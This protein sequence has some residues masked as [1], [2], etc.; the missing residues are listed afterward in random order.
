MEQYNRFVSSLKSSVLAEYAMSKYSIGS[1]NFSC[2]EKADVEKMIL[3]LKPKT[4][5]DITLISHVTRKY[6]KFLGEDRVQNILDDICREELWK[7]AKPNA[8]RRFISFS[9]YQ[10][11]CDKIDIYEDYNAFYKNVLFRCIYE[12]IYSKKL[13]VI[14]NLRASDIHGN[15]VTLRDDDGDTFVLAISKELAEDLKELGKVN[16][17]DRTNGLGEF[18]VWIDG[19]HY[20]SCFKV[21]YRGGDNDT[22]Y[23]TSYLR[24]LREICKLYL[25]RKVSPMKIYVSGIMHRIGVELTK[26]GLSIEEA[27]TKCKGDKRVLAII[28]E[29]LKRSGYSNPE[30]C[31]REYVRGHLDEFD[32]FC[33]IS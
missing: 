28:R 1:L 24:A 31:L 4:P 27:F 23:R 5:R 33:D 3:D 25:N 18:S 11:V 17:W 29:E 12:G 19:M 30:N 14:K 15:T 6:A 20:D 21:E 9:E 32:E 8:P 26:E 22:R 7:K 16:V 13:S 2:C 10:N